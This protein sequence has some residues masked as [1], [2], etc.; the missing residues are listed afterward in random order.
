P[1]HMISK[2]PRRHVLIHSF[3]V[4][5]HEP[6]RDTVPQIYDLGRQSIRPLS[7][8]AITADD[9]A[10]SASEAN[11]TMATST[12]TTALTLAGTKEP[13]SK[14]H[15]FLSKRPGGS[16][17]PGSRPG[18]GGNPGSGSGPPADGSGPPGGGPLG[19]LPGG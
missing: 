4:R 11:N 13:T 3:G 10:P 6:R 7:I 5:V 8:S 16:G 19:G 12:L 2:R 1:T 15:S 17:P 18:G 14:V 9:P